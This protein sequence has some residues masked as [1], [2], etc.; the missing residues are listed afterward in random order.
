MVGTT[1]SGNC[2][3]G[4]VLNLVKPYREMRM[5]T[6]YMA[7][8]LSTDQLVSRNSLNFFD[9]PSKTF[10]FVLL[11]F[12]CLTCSSIASLQFEGE[13]FSCQFDHL[14]FV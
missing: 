10:M 12:R 14:S 4:M 8:L 5:V 11:M 3:L 7:V 9:S 13:L 6:I 1:M 2:S